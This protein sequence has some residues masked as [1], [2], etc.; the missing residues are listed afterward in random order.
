[1]K[2]IAQLSKEISK[3]M[4]REGEYSVM[5]DSEAEIYALESL[6]DYISWKFNGAIVNI[7]QEDTK[8]YD[9]AMRAQRSLPMRPAIYV[10]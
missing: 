1:M 10:E 3:E 4:P 8:C 7:L 2:Q 5:L 9:P 6:K